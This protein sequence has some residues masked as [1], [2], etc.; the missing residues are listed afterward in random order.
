[1]PK[2]DALV[3]DPGLARALP[4][5]VLIE[6]QRQVRHVSAD[7][8][9]AI[10]RQTIQGQSKPMIAEVLGVEEAAK[11]LDTSSDSLYR[12]RERLRLGYIDPL[13]RRLKFTAQEIAEYIRRQKRG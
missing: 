7:L 5:E 12:K 1:V 6:L 9:A 3:A 10:A 4:L 11:R 8:G 13:D 2:L